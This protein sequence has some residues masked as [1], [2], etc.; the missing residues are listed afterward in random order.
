MSNC[1]SLLG[2]E[3]SATFRCVYLIDTWFSH[4]SIS[5]FNKWNFLLQSLKDLDNNLRKLKSRLFVIKG[6]PADVFPSLFKG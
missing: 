5:G 6:Q 2:L 3:Q 4:S 1:L